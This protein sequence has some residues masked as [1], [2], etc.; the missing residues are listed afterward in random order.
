MTS[1]EHALYSRPLDKRNGCDLTVS[2]LDDYG[3]DEDSG[4]Y[5]YG[6]VVSV[7]SQGFVIGEGSIWAV[8]AADDDRFEDIIEYTMGTYG[9]QLIEEA[10]AAAKHTV[11]GVLL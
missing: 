4:N 5:L 7:V 2:V 9:E 11:E 6:V 10:L 3:W 1:L 8:A